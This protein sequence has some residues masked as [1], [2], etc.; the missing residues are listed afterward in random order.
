VTAAAAAALGLA[1]GPVHAELRLGPG[2]PVVLEVAAR[3]IG[4]LCARTLRFGAGVSL[5]EIIVAHAVGLP[6][7]ALRREAAASGVMMLPIPRAGV[8]HGVRGIEEARAV[9]GVVDVAV[10]IPLGRTVEPLP[11][12]DS[13]LGFLFARGASP[14][15]VERA[16]RTAHARLRFEIRQALATA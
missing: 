4:G 9:P 2:G 5:E 3:S 6:V 1:E 8:L 13:Y 15:E 14:E 16:L 12:G 7:A 11:E 10:T